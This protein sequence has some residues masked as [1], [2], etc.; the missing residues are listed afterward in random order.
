M[1]YGL[2]SSTVFLL[3]NAVVWDL[4]AAAGGPDGGVNEQTERHHPQGHDRR[5]GRHTDAEDE[6][7]TDKKC[8]IHYK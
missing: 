6:V 8:Q 5:T 7:N 1:L 4:D 2:V 3:T